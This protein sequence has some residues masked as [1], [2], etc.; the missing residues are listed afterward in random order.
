MLS[1][2]NLVTGPPVL[3]N[4]GP[5]GGKVIIVTGSSSGIG[6][7]VVKALITA[8]AS[9]VLVARREKQLLEL[10]ETFSDEV[11]GRALISCADVTDSNAMK[12]VVIIAETYFNSSI[13]GLINC[14]GVM[15]YQKALDCDEISWSQQIDVNCK[16]VLNS[17][18]SVLPSMK[19]HRRGHIINI[20]SDAGKKVFTGLAVY[21]ATKHFVQAFSEG[22]RQEC[23][24]YGIK[25][26]NIQPGDVKT[27][28]L[29]HTRDM[30]ALSEFGPGIDAEML[31][32]E[33]ISNAIL[34]ALNQ[35]GRCAVNE[36][37]IEPT[38]C[39]I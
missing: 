2:A 19:T 20:S 6:A 21:S 1:S 27:E 31:E 8:G 16:G 7:G 38:G 25:V 32:V 29:S 17:I 13:W 14:A 3:E 28:L 39:P 10:V 30:N 22:L 33:D 26:T 23:A 4:I 15:H 18:A 24:P 9:V 36:I 37:L 5:L 34:F 35:N 11:R 12:K